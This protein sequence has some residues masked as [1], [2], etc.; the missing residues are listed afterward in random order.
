MTKDVVQKMIQQFNGIS[1]LESAKRLARAWW[2]GSSNLDKLNVLDAIYDTYDHPAMEAVAML[3]GMAF[4]ELVLLDPEIKEDGHETVQGSVQQ[5]LPQ[6][7]E[8]GH[9]GADEGGG[10]GLSR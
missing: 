7:P 2:Q 3:A 8:E 6:G 10:A 1:D 5:T 4:A 9:P